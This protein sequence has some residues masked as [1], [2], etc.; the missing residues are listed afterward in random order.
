MFTLVASASE[1]LSAL[2]DSG[3]RREEYHAVIIG[4]ESEG[5]HTV[6]D[7]AS[8]LSRSYPALT[9]VLVSSDNWEEIEYN[10]NRSGI[11]HFIPLPFFR[12]SLIN[13]LNQALQSTGGAESGSAYPNLEGKR[14]LLVE[15]NM[16]NR[17]IARELLGMTR[18]EIETAEDGKQAVDM[19]LASPEGWYDLILMDVQMP[20]MD[21][22]AAT[23]AIRS[24]ARSDSASIPIYAMTA[25]TFAEDIAKARSAGMNGHIA[26]PIDVNLLMQ[27]LR[28]VER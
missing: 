15:D 14:L 6:L 5:S 1:A 22:Y 4:S 25:N 9:L 19:F 20:V 13:G 26:K 3:F 17:E 11:R 24:S 21:G 7:T 27:T 8:Y 10:A 16:I 18:A 2:T 12:K 23:G 28:Q